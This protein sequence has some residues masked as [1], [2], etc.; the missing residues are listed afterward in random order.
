MEFDTHITSF[1]FLV[2]PLLPVTGYRELIIFLDYCGGGDYMCS[3]T[4]PNQWR[5]GWV[6][7]LI[8]RRGEFALIKLPTGNILIPV[9][10]MKEKAQ[11]LLI[12]TFYFLSK[13]KARGKIMNYV[14]QLSEIMWN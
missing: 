4:I 8:R 11:I 9:H 14:T 1:D 7:D 13:G 10:L 2:R 12:S 3:S 5:G 6:D